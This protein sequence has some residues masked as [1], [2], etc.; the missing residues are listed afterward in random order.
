VNST[1]LKPNDL[2]LLRER[3]ISVHEIERQLALFARPPHPVKLVRPCTL[4]DGIRRIDADEHRACLAAFEAARETGRCLKFVP[5]SGAASRMFAA[6]LRILNRP[7]PLRREDLRALAAGGDGAARETLRVM[8]EMRRLPFRELLRQALAREGLDLA[9]LLTHGDY[10]PILDALLTPHGLELAQFPKGLLPFH[11]YEDGPRT[12]FEEHL[13]E[14]AAY[15]RDGAGR[16]RMHFTVSPEHQ[17]RFQALLDAVRPGYERKYGVRYDVGF[18]SQKPATDTLAVGLDNQPFRTEDGALVLRPG[19]HGALLENLNDLQ[20]DLVFIKNIDNVTNEDRI[21]QTV[22]WKRLLGGYLCLLQQRIFGHRSRLQGADERAVEAAQR[23]TV[24]ELGI[25]VPDAVQAAGTAARRDF[26]RRALHRPLRV[27]GMVR[28]T[29]EPGGGPFWVRDARGE[30]GVRVVETAEIDTDSEEQRRI[31]GASTHFSPVD[32]A[33]GLRDA[34]GRHFVL[35]QYV[36]PDAVC[37]SEKSIGGRGLR[38]LEHPG[39]WNGGMAYWITV[40]VEVP[41]ATFNPV[42]TVADLLRPAHQPR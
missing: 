37:I 3:G 13:V 21:E 16:C 33:C 6:L 1:E 15:A 12:A 40:F 18:S 32:L 22:L 4:G 27:C 26:L 35:R 34:E 5:A 17:D 25:E 2:E 39:L 38:A 30:L 42:K 14:A 29:G 11:R 8:E 24:Q 41:D 28:N 7:G 23:F 19:G 10:R 20:A 31:L 9:A 36:D